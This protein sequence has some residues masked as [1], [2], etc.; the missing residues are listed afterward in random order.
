MPHSVQ[1]FTRYPPAET[2]SVCGKI[3]QAGVVASVWFGAEGWQQRI[4]SGQSP[5]VQVKRELS[6]EEEYCVAGLFEIRE[7]SCG[8]NST[9]SGMAE[10]EEIIS[11]QE[12]QS[13]R[14]LNVE[15][16]YKEHSACDICPQQMLPWQQAPLSMSCA[17]CGLSLMPEEGIFIAGEVT[18]PTSRLVTTS[19]RKV[20]SAS[21]AKRRL[22]I[23]RTIP[24]IPRR[25]ASCLWLHLG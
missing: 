13:F 24:K 18:C 22:S 7:K 1:E 16:G 8:A 5:S 17:C 21:S 25:I 14:L 10:T 20:V 23:S 4:S 6:S 15:S 3:S 11:W 9:A 12:R 19:A 2:H